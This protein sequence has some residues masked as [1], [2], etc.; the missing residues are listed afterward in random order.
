MADRM[1]KT[2]VTLIAV[3]L[4]VALF[5]I[6]CVIGLIGFHY[7]H[8]IED[9]PLKFPI[10]VVQIEGHDLVLEDGRRMALDD[11][12]E[13]RG[14]ISEVLAQSD[15]QIDVEPLVGETYAVWAR[16]DGWICGT[17]WAQPIRIPIFKDTVY[18]NRRQPV[19]IARG[20][21]AEP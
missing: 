9:E 13:D 7:P 17:P 16:Q 20:T 3:I 1:T 4:V 19:G 5:V 11:W 6:A 2:R 10:K 12:T 14:T 21:D 15:F 18:C 8:V